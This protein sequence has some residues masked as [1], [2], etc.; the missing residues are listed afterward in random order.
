MGTIKEYTNYDAVGLAELVK[1]GEVKPEELLETAIERCEEVNPRINAVVHKQYDQAL[2]AI[3]SGLPAGP[4]RGVP[5]LLKDLYALQEGE[6]SW[7]GSELFDGFVSDHD[8]T[9][10]RRCKDAGLV[11]MG[12]TN[13]PEFGLNIDTAP[14]KHGATHN[15]WNLDHS[16]GGSSG[17]AAAAVAAGILPVAHATDGGGSIRIPAA[18]CGLVGLKPT[19]ARNPS[20]PDAGEGW[21]GLSAGHVVSRTVRDSAGFLDCTHGPAPGD[22]Y[23]APEVKGSFADEV[24]A[25][26]GKLKIALVASGYSG[27]TVHPQ[28][29]A[30]AENTAKLCE[31]LG[32]HVE[33]A[34]PELDM[35][36]MFEAMNI[37]ISANVWNA[38]RFRYAALKREPDGEGVESITWEFFKAGLKY[39]AGDY[40]NAL[41][42]IHRC[43]RQLGEFFRNYDL[44]LSPTLSNPPLKLREIVMTIPSLE[45]Y[46]DQLFGE[47]PVTPVY[48]VTGCPAISLPLH[49]SES[50]LPIGVHFGASFGKEALL[51]RLASQIE[52]AQP[53]FDHLPTI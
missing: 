8:T 39:K 43:G 16:V 5:F 45:K 1:Q 51:L 11:I 36:S 52:E 32:H 48:N 41:L 46:T 30:G 10:T 4:F 33:V 44:I 28:C 40:A 3:N 7:N 35:G 26:P 14:Q 42:T 47:L 23:H 37:I 6:P 29:A 50:G 22:P 17:G 31:T 15:P 24:G 25:D 20:G 53:W 21:S 38:L 19:R 49:R 18:N 12:R 13:S 27:Q 34:R 9:Y 2:T